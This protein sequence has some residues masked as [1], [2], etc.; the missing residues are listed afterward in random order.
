VTEQ[1]QTPTSADNVVCDATA[2]PATAPAGRSRFSRRALL[3]G[4][5][6]GVAAAALGAG[7][8]AAVTPRQVPEVVR[9]GGP[10]TAAHGLRVP[11]RLAGACPGK[12]VQVRGGG[13]ELDGKPFRF[14]GSNCYYLHQQ[15]HYMID[16]VLDDAAAMGLPVIRAWAFADGSGNGYTALQPQL[17]VYDEDAFDSLDYAVHRA[18]Q[19]G[20][21][22]VLPLVNNWPDYGGMRQ[23]VSWVLGLPD[24]TYGDNTNHDLFYT[25][26]TIRR[27]YKAYVKHVVTRRN[28]YT[29]LRYNEDP[30]IMTFELTNESRCRT[31]KSG[32][33][34]LAWVREMSAY[35]R[36]LAPRQLV[37]LGDEGFY[38]DP[39]DYDYP[40]STYEGVSWK[41]I[42]ALPSI[43]YGTAHLYPQGWG[44]SDPVAWGT[45]WIT[46]HITDARALGK[47]LVLEEYGVSIGG[48]G[49]A[50]TADRDAAYR[51]WTGTVLSAGGAGDQFWLL[52]S[53]VDDGSYYPDYDGFRI[54]WN[55]D[56]SNPSASTTALLAAHAK[57]MADAA[58]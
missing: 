10:H 50:G 30:T 33:T 36:S 56:P 20:I 45:K 27:Y 58:S 23:Y 47:P 53:R 32:A 22:L 49:I 13:F 37:A 7:R 44:E 24:D 25:D 48:A 5:A 46:D 17:G 54:T 55:A 2:P 19:L 12:F 29:G 18:G 3:G 28:R 41:Q 6:T 11:A 51:T 43:D 52:T 35:L 39:A 1:D 42:V 15:S 57:A 38:G 9:R 26:A 34:L 31:D 16:N 8:A 14:G 4:A 21:R 40:Y